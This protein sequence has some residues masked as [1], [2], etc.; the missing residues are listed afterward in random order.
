MRASAQ[1]TVVPISAWEQVKT[2]QGSTITVKGGQL[3]ATLIS[4]E[5]A[6]LF[7]GR[8][9]PWGVALCSRQGRAV[10]QA[11]HS[12]LQRP[13]EP[14]PGWVAGLSWDWCP[15]PHPQSLWGLVS[16][17]AQPQEAAA[18]LKQTVPSLWQAT[19]IRQGSGI[20]QCPWLGEVWQPMLTSRLLQ[21]SSYLKLL[22][23]K[24]AR[25]LF[26]YMSQY[27]LYTLN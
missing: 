6:F 9:Q 16:T 8:K 21:P 4:R 11:E 12:R 13:G 5:N 19:D 7:W 14:Q 1:G 22:C 23:Q 2:D 18:H 26:I 10:K 3:K 17:G 15:V 25:E 24:P 27:K 20:C